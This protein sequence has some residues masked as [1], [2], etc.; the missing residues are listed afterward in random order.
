MLG[1]DRRKLWQPKKSLGNG[2]KSFDIRKPC[3]SSASSGIG[4]QSEISPHTCTLG[5]SDLK[6]YQGIRSYAC[7]ITVHVSKRNCYFCE[8]KAEPIALPFCWKLKISLCFT[9]LHIPANLL[10]CLTVVNTKCLTGSRHSYTIALCLLNLLPARV[11]DEKPFYNRAYLP[12]C[13]SW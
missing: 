5:L 2:V 6:F 9:P 11:P 10:K 12:Y 7:R 3:G 13:G 4:I 1:Q 8:K